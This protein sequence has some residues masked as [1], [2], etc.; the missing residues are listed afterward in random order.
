MKTS[1]TIINGPLAG[2]RYETLR[3]ARKAGMG[4]GLFTILFFINGVKQT[5]TTFDRHGVIVTVR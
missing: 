3:E 1:A 2:T 5:A 4:K